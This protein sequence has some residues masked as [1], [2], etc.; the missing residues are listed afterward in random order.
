MVVS[1]D[2][3]LKQAN[4]VSSA[5]EAI[6]AT[7]RVFDARKPSVATAC[8]A[9]GVA[10]VAGVA[11]IGFGW[12]LMWR[13]NV[14]L[15]PNP[16]EEARQ[17]RLAQR[18]KLIERYSYLGKA[19]PTIDAVSFARGKVLYGLACIACHGP[20]GRGVKGLGKDL[21]ASDFAQKLSDADFVAFVAKGRPANDPFN[22]TKIPMPAR[23]GRAD[24]A[25][26]DLADVVNFLRGLQDPRRAPEEPLPNVTVAQAS[27]P[28]PA[29]EP[30]KP[31]SADV[32]R[33]V[34]SQAI[35]M[36][37]A[38]RGKK[39]FVSCM[40]C[41][42]KDGKGIKNMGKDLTHSPFVA[43]Q[44]NDQ[45]LAF[46]KRGRDPGDPLNT[47]KVAMPPKGGNPAL[48]EAQLKDVIQ[49]IRSLQKAAVEKK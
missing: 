7:P 4:H 41:H 20:E 10:V 48:N 1:G 40:A 8:I 35:D 18:Q 6:A 43:E 45:L 16:V 21:V 42:G 34:A 33:Q 23:G 15:V 32:T 29:A 37:A 36:D 2:P 14:A 28:P 17:E 9:A 19:G 39:V 30:A 46:I 24:F 13:V 44:T 5:G 26:N 49:Y 12:L 25:D 11:A 22:T 27:A 3:R 31:L 47:T 38:T